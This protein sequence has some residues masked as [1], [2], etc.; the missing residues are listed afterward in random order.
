MEV[1]SFEEGLAEVTVTLKRLQ[2]TLL[3]HQ[4]KLEES[5]RQARQDFSLAR[6][7]FTLASEKFHRSIKAAIK[8]EINQEGQVDFL[9]VKLNQRSP[10]RKVKKNTIHLKHYSPPGM[11]AKSFEEGLAEVTETLKRLQSTL[12]F[13]QYKLEE[14]L[15][16]ARQDF[17]LA[18]QDFTLASEKFHRSIK[19]AIKKEINHEGQVD[20]L[21]VQ[22]NQRSPN[23]K[24]K[25]KL[26]LLSGRSS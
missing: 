6:Q 22:L 14:S 12:L 20:F 5:F 24:V 17:S 10:N 26:F 3:F 8:K 11:E 4:S 15:R 25:A 23:S 16:Q 7:D 2:S 1:K 21:G 18:R 19:A 9:G 13:H